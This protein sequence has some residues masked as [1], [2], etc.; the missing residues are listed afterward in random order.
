L[1]NV[2]DTKATQSIIGNVRDS[3]F[4]GYLQSAALV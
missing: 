3:I 1:T 2:V 4:R